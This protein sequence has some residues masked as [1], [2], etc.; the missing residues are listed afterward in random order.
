MRVHRIF[1]LRFPA[2]ILTPTQIGFYNFNYAV[3]KY[4]GLDYVEDLFSPGK[5][6]VVFK[7]R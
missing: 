4:R 2:V 1:S 3:E 5:F 7:S 6:I